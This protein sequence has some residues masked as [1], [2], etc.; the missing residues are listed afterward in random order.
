MYLRQDYYYELPERL[1]AQKPV[2]G[3]KHARLLHLE[4]ASGGLGHNRFTDLPKLLRAGDL[5]VVNNTA[6]VPGRL[7]GHKPTGGRVEV[8]I[9]DYHV[10]RRAPHG[11]RVHRCMVRASKPVRPGMRLVFNPRLSAEVLSAADGIATLRFDCQVDFDTLLADVG[12]IPLPPYIRRTAG[13]TDADRQSY[14]TVYASQK[15]AIA[16]PTAGLHFTKD[17]LDEL[18]SSGIEIVQVTL[19]VGYGTF[20]PVRVDDIREHQMHPE[21]YELTEP[22][23]AAINVAK[24]EGRRVIAVGTTAVRTLETCAEP[25]GRLQAGNGSCELFIYPGY[26]FKA[27]DALI[28]NFHLPES[29][30]LMLVAAL[31][32]RERIL[33]AYREAVAA[34]Y[35]F[36]SYGDAMLIT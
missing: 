1:I 9:L 2:P 15:G 17:L 11:A 19:H 5:L 34:E 6:V 22:V 7:Y 30:L 3:R 13:A 29:T 27:V 21:W 20:V 23:A 10:G 33:A 32:G 18:T 36:F 28:T 8:L 24:A 4:R 12:Q 35:R 16:A 14:Q 26:R 31:V 25:D